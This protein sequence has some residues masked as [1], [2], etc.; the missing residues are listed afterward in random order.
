MNYVLG[1]QLK[2]LRKEHGLSQS[3]FG[4]LMHVSNTTVSNW[5]T[6]FSRPSYEEL[7]KMAIFFNVSIDF[8]L[9]FQVEDSHNMER[10]KKALKDTGTMEDDNL[11]KSELEYAL[12]QVAMLREFRRTESEYKED[13]NK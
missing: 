4:K 3:E 9:D 12:K 8:L 13:T 10:L 11:T 7:K 1:N 2:K 6:E 5:E